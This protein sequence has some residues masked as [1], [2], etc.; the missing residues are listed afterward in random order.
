[1]GK[2]SIELD[3]IE[4]LR[5]IQYLFGVLQN[6]DFHPDRWKG[7]GANGY[8]VRHAADVSKDSLVCLRQA[9]LKASRDIQSAKITAQEFEEL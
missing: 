2:N 6:T 8:S 3:V 4:N 1:M 5:A 9:L 7:E